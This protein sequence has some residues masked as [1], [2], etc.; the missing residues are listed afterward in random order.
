MLT[1]L[2]ML[3]D[4]ISGMEISLLGYAVC[5]AVYFLICFLF[6]SNRAGKGIVFLSWLICELL[7]DV[8]WYLIFYQNGN[9]VN[10]GIGGTTVLFL[11]PGTLFVA[12]VSV[13]VINDKKR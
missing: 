2:Y 8:L 5:V 11:L 3:L 9:Y 12:A 10:Y 4:G 1:M 6:R 7:C 13:T